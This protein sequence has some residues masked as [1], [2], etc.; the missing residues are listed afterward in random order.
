VH[1]DGSKECMKCLI[2]VVAN[3][4]G[5]VADLLLEQIR[6]F[7][8]IAVSS[9]ADNLVYYDIGCR[10]VSQLI[11]LHESL[12]LAVT[13]D[14]FLFI[15]VLKYIEWR[16][17]WQ[18]S[19]FVILSMVDRSV[20]EISLYYHNSGNKKLSNMKIIPIIHDKN[21]F[22]GFDILDQDMTFKGLISFLDNFHRHDWIF[23]FNCCQSNRN[24]ADTSYATFKS[25]NCDIGSDRGG[26]QQLESIRFNKDYAF[27]T[28]NDA[29]C[30][31]DLSNGKPSGLCQGGCKNVGK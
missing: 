4:L 30:L 8:F 28:R 3:A 13:F 22:L 31:A 26:K 10:D 15:D 9:H 19:V 14:S 7:A 5:V 6:K 24:T 21:H 25:Q 1:S 29:A 23:R 16:P 12:V 20:T 17:E 27:K 2:L 11:L 18:D